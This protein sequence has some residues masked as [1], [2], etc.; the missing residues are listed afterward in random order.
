MQETTYPILDIL[1]EN[2][3]LT[4]LR[5]INALNQW[6]E[7]DDH[8]SMLVSACSSILSGSVTR[9]DLATAHTCLMLWQ[10]FHDRLPKARQDQAL[11]SR[12]M[13][14]ADKLQQLCTTLA[15]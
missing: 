6:L 1:T 13:Q 4:V 9:K 7:N 11:A 10:Q 2:E 15:A 14:I 8:N 12:I 5:L 3:Q